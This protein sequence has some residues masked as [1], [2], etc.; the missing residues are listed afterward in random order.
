M[1]NATIRIVAVLVVF[2]FS[3]RLAKASEP[4]LNTVEA[5]PSP[6]VS[7]ALSVGVTLGG[8]GLG[9]GMT[10]SDDQ[11][12]AIGGLFVGAL[13]LAIGPSVGQ[14]YTGHWLKG[15]FFLMGRFSFE[16]LVVSGV[17]SDF[18]FDNCSG[19]NESSGSEMVV[20]GLI[21]LA[22]LAIWDIVD[23]TYDAMAQ[24]EAA[25]GP[26][27]KISPTLIPS[28]RGP[29]QALAFGLSLFGMF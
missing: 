28:G 18:C 16:A 24:Q 21:G 5:A 4:S 7:L 19:R 9:L 17:L 27:F 6:W 1:K 23:S 13:S 29:D 22:G 25:Q 12:L 2:A 3:T 26:S 10:Q 8:F 20:V 15:M 14:F 11:D